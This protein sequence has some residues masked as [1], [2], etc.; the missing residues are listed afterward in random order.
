MFSGNR[1]CK[2]SGQAI[3]ADGTVNF[4]VNRAF[5]E[6]CSPYIQIKNC[7]LIFKNVIQLFS[8]CQVCS[9]DYHESPRDK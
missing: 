2:V 6:G 7:P 9:G 3:L 8:V 1:K 4:T 5:P